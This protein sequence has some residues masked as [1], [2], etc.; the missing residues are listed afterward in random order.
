M[1]MILIVVVVTM[2]ALVGFGVAAKAHNT[3]TSTATTS[4]ASENLLTVAISGCINKPGTYKLT[5]GKTLI[6]LITAAGGVTTNADSLAYNANHL[7]VAKDEYYIAPIY[8]NANTCSTDPILK[9][10]VNTASAD[11][12]QTIAGFSKSVSA[13]VVSYRATASFDTL[14]QI[15]EVKGCGQ[16]TYITVRDKITLRDY[17]D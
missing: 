12:L 17:A 4:L 9:C 2:V 15:K 13:A 10:N 5:A 16:A 14:E 7:L 8:D 11:L 3:I 1:K 6:D